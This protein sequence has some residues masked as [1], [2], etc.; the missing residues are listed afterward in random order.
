MKDTISRLLY[1][2]KAL[3]CVYGHV[4]PEIVSTVCWLI[5]KLSFIIKILPN[6][7]LAPE[8]KYWRLFLLILTS[9]KTSSYCKTNRNFCRFNIFFCF[10]V[11]L[12]FYTSHAASQRATI[13]AKL[14]PANGQLPFT[15]GNFKE[16]LSTAKH[17][18][19]K[20]YSFCATRRTDNHQWRTIFQRDLC[21]FLFIPNQ[22]NYSTQR[23]YS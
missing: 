10:Y 2:M 20:H 12:V 8:E 14:T 15:Y 22:I 16:T 7:E 19:F 9:T 13:S 11:M 17:Y 1:P 18:S 3:C 4:G 23:S 5:C 21:Y 6:K